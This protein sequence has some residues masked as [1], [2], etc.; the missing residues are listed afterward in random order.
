MF[1]FPIAFSALWCEGIGGRVLEGDG[2]AFP[3]GEN[4]G[5]NSM[6]AFSA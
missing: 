5:W 2:E 6:K 1:S 4:R 3:C